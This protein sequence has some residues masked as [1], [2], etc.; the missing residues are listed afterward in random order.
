MV[1]T[2]Q[3]IVSKHTMFYLFILENQQ[4]EVISEA[5]CNMNNIKYDL[6]LKII[7]HWNYTWKYRNVI[8]IFSRVLSFF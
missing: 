3:F 4:V 6:T 1:T 8:D 2:C 7:W 5:Q